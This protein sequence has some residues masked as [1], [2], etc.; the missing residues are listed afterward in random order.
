MR[1]TA[2][3]RDLATV[4]AFRT[5]LG[6]RLVSQSG[7]G[8]VQAG[9]ATLF[10]FQP[11]NMTDAAGVA[12]A[13][14]VMLLPFSVVGPFAGPFIDRWRRRRTLLIGNLVR[15]GLIAATAVHLSI[16]G[17]GPVVY[18]LVLVA[19][20]INRFLLSVLSA[21]LPQVI[22]HERL[23]VA[24]SIVPTLGGAA[25]AVGGVL[26]LLLRLLLPAGTAQDAGSLVVAVG[27]Y[28]LAAGVVSRLGVDELGPERT[29][30][31]TGL[32]SAIAAT[33]GD[34]T[35]AVRYLVRRGTPGLALT[36]MALHRFVYGMELIALI[37][38]A[39]NLLA[40]PEDA[41]AGLAVFG[42]LMGA[43][44]AGHGLAV[45]LTPLAHERVS[46][47]SW[48][49]MCLIGGT[50]GQLVL[51]TTHALTAV[52]SGLLVFGVGVQGAKIAVDTIVQADTV[53]AYRGRAFSIYDVLFNTAECVA[54]GVAVL[55]LPPIGWS[56]SVQAVLVVLVWTVALVYRGRVRALGDRPR[57]VDD[58]VA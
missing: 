49:V 39:R 13:L 29:G 3:L 38:M 12:A 7:D 2:D 41:D 23:L 17:I 21:G 50:A 26:G 47:S 16:A 28:V 30:R 5:L 37:L 32:A 33:A 20:G 53:D 25:T 8:M 56:R 46:P 35:D 27:L 15:A 9:L 51:V 48:V 44:L 52:A 42:T 6:V 22:D 54:A 40:V 43:M 11:Q 18:V 31:R 45:V 19:L 10:F 55:V 36:A 57:L 14:V 24:N 4:P 58:L 1:L 34:L